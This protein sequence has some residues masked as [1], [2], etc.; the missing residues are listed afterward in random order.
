MNMRKIALIL[1]LMGL[2]IAPGGLV[3]AQETGSSTNQVELP[4]LGKML[5]DNPL[6][7]V[8]D[9]LG[10]KTLKDQVQMGMN[11]AQTELEALPGKA[12]DKAQE[13][14]KAELERQADKAVQGAQ[15]RAQGY[16]GG[17]VNII[18]EKVSGIIESIKTFFKD[19]FSKRP[20][21]Y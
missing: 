18:K 12:L 2:V 11:K 19:L 17:V 10:G 5:P 9:W 13:A 1:A 16:V 6:E 8:S 15:E 3:L 20:A 14:A 4:D 21:T 7:R